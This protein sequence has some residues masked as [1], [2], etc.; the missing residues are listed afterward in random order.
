MKSL[1]A[2]REFVK[3]VLQ[4]VCHFKV[5]DIAGNAN[6]AAYRYHENQEYQYL[7]NSSVAVMR[8]ETQCEVNTGQPFENRLHIYYSTNN[9]PLQLHA[10]DDLY[11]CF[12]AILSWKASGTQNHE[13]AWEFFF[14][15]QMVIL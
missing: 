13:E 14:F 15:L 7:Y 6:A 9:H 10:A 4:K 8:R 3:T 2:A 5:D 1:A 12:M 11:C